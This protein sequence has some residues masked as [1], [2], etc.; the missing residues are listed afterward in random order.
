MVQSIQVPFFNGLRKEKWWISRQYH[1]W[2]THY[3]LYR[4]GGVINAALS[5]SAVRTGPCW[6]VAFYSPMH[7]HTE[8]SSGSCIIHQYQLRCAAPFS[9]RHPLARLR[10]CWVCTALQPTVIFKH[11]SQRITES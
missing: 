1:S 9:L 3:S 2:H 6:E 8:Q 5:I 4:K 7:A 11:K 10:I